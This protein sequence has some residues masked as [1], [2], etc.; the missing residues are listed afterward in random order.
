MFSIETEK[1]LKAEPEEIPDSLN[2]T[3]AH[4]EDGIELGET[5]DFMAEQMKCLLCDDHFRSSMEMEDHLSEEHQIDREACRAFAAWILNKTT[6]REGKYD[7]KNPRCNG[8]RENY[9]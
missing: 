5:Q 6:A 2:E 1:M 9:H 8:N 7:I 4:V 3:V